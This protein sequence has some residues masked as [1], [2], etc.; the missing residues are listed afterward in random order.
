MRYTTCLFIG[1]KSSQEKL[2]SYPNP[3][4]CVTLTLSIGPQA[5]MLSYAVLTRVLMIVRCVNPNRNSR[6]TFTYF[7]TLDE[8]F[9]ALKNYTRVK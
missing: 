1:L 2:S 4:H 7:L 5:S 8:Y 9:T 3:K 6:H